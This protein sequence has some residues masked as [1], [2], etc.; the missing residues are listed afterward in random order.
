MN[1]VSPPHTFFLFVKNK[2]YGEGWALTK[3]QQVEREG[4]GSVHR[5]L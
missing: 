3:R 5:V 1:M 2:L 4:D